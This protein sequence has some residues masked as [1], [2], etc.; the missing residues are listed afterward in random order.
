MNKIISSQFLLIGKSIVNNPSLI[1]R[2]LKSDLKIKWIR[3]EKVSPMH[4]SK[5]GDLSEFPKI[6]KSKYC[7]DFEMSKEL[8]T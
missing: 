2:T 5:S 4:P 3:P 8:E 6:D 7:L 1:V